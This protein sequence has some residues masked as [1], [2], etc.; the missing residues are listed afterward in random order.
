M[1]LNAPHF[2]SKQER[3]KWLVANKESI[4]MLKKQETKWG[5]DIPYQQ[6]FIADKDAVIKAEQPI[7]L[8]DLNF[9][10]VRAVINTTNFM[11]S[12]LDVHIPGLWDKSLKENKLL[13]H[14][15]EHKM[16]FDAIISDGKDLKAYTEK[17]SWKELGFDF[18]GTTEALIF[19]SVVR[20][21]R[22]KFMFEQYGK[23]YVKNH[24][25]GMQYVSM[26]MA[27]DDKDHG[28]EFEAWEKYFPM[29]VNKDF[30]EEMGVFWAI[31]EA[32]VRE[33]SAVPLGSNRTTPTLDNN[34]KFEPGNHSKDEPLE[35]TQAVDYSYLKEHL[36]LC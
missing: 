14:L 11:D 12:H 29:I 8:T 18:P 20:K 34:L 6:L 1:I 17:Y 27:I 15:Q 30:A 4:I 22:N 3:N 36:N 23:G 9:L 19:D 35:G 16:A 24:S 7:D 5:E 10:K 25:V 31:K 33:G 13:M 26:V 2:T 32:K 21:A 28:A